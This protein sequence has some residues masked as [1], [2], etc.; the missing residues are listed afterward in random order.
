VKVLYIFGL[1][2]QI[3]SDISDWS[4]ELHH[5]FDYFNNKQHEQHKVFALEELDTLFDKTEHN[6]YFEKS[7]FGVN[8]N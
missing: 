1:Q 7:I 2:P 4:W 5:A 3:R 6:S 8:K